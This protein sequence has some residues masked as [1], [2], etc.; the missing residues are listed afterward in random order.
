MTQSMIEKLGKKELIEILGK[1]WMTHDGMWFYNT[2]MENGVESA[3]KINKAAIKSL[4][5]IEIHRCK[6]LMGIEPIA[7]YD[8]LKEFFI[9]IAELLIPE[10]M[11]ISFEFPDNNMAT[12]KFNEKKCF[13]YNG[14][15]MLGV[16]DK[17][18]CGPIYRIRCWL[19]ALG[20][21][22]VLEPEI[23]KCVMPSKGECSGKIV[24][25]F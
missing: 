14:I 1:C 13:A 20:V 25:K 7:S 12:W 6:K 22:Y 3:N 17:Y 24:F 2:L 9:G 19:D 23:G 10:F 18:E 8:V 4:A 16:I 21:T 5:P 15:S 11:N